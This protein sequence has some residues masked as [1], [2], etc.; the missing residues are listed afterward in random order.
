MLGFVFELIPARITRTKAGKQSQIN[1]CLLPLPHRFSLLTHPPREAEIS[2]LLSHR[3]RSLA[4]SLIRQWPPPP[5]PPPASCYAS[6]LSTSA[7]HVRA[8]SCLPVFSFLRSF[9]KKIP[10]FLF[11]PAWIDWL[12][13]LLMFP[14]SSRVEETDLVLHAAVESQQRLH[15]LQGPFV[16]RGYFIF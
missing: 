13:T 3:A 1:T 6:N 10:F 8:P 16:L 15:R 11:P 14:L 7:S 9:G 12:V 2:P 4:A 5:L